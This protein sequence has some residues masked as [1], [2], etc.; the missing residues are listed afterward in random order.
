MILWTIVIGLGLLHFVII[1][2]MVRANWLFTQSDHDAERAFEDYLRE[3]QP[4]QRKSA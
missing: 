2:A 3:R 1:V 4:P